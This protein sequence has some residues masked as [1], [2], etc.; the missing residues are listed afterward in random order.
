MNLA[1][2]LT[3]ASL[4]VADAAKKAKGW[5]FE[6]D[7][8]DEEEAAAQPPPSAAPGGA[9]EPPQRP[10]GDEVSAPGTCLGPS[11]PRLVLFA[12]PCCVLDRATSLAPLSS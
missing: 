3:L 10:P 11:R 12:A 6:D 1:R 5:S 2:S 4:T 7:S 9:L 8:E